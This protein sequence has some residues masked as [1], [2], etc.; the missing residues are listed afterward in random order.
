MPDTAVLNIINLNIDS[1]QAEIAK[2][3][4]NK[5]QEINAVVEGCTNRHTGV[6]N[7]Q[8]ANGQNDQNNSNKSI[9]YF[10]SSKDTD[11]DKR[12]SSAMTQTIHETFGN[13]FNGN[14]C[15]E[16]T[17][18][19]QLKPDSKPYQVPPR[20]VAYVLQKPF[21]EELECLR[22]PT[23]NDIL[24]RLNNVQYMS[25]I[26]ASS[27]YH[28]LKLD[29]QSSYLTT[30]TCQFGRY[31]YKCLPFGAVP[32]GNMFQHKIGEIF[33]D[34]PNVFGNADDILVIGQMS[35]QVHINTILWQSSFKRRHPMRSAKNQSTD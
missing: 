25:I 31:R 34:M 3:K 7:K 8:D 1:I 9:N 26:D 12:K 18:S 33:N 32:A 29:T 30:F 35:F 23:L 15:F 24:P 21:K 6:I 2:C 22:G 28:N 17:F 14:G 10:H 4:T 16:G 19:L 5:G 27:G 11:A 20:H 13:I